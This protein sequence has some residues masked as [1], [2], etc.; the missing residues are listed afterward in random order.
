MAYHENLPNQPID[1]EIESFDGSVRTAIPDDH[2][3][4]EEHHNPDERSQLPLG[5]VGHP[6]PRPMMLPPI[7]FCQVFTHA[8]RFVN[9]PERYDFENQG[10]EGTMHDAHPRPPTPENQP[11]EGLKGSHWA[12]LSVLLLDEPKSY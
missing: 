12:N 6:P 11:L 5:S 9:P 7:P 4:E 1:D 2:C 8:G 3:F 10:P